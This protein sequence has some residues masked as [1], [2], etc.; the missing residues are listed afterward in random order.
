M[1]KEGYIQAIIDTG[2]VAVIRVNNAAELLETAIALHKGECGRWNYH[3]LT[4]SI[5]GDQQA[6]Q[7]LG[8]DAIIGVGSVLDPE[9]ARAA[10]LA[11]PNLWSPRAAH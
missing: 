7:K 11:G 5:G 6:V 3:D 1:N 4:R 9:T 2:I 8:E 10:I